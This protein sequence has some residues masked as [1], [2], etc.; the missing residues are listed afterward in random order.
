MTGLVKVLAWLDLHETKLRSLA[1]FIHEPSHDSPNL[2][3]SQVGS[4]CVTLCSIHDHKLQ[5]K[6]IGQTYL[7]TNLVRD[8]VNESGKWCGQSKH[9]SR[10][11]ISRT[12]GVS[13]ISFVAFSART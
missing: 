5:V 6:T 11:R 13:M 7:N 12:R 1:T 8:C 9:A 2:C 10:W 4:A 3:E